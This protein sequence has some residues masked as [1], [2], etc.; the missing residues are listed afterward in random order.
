M[1]VDQTRY[2]A[3]DF[4]GARILQ[5]RE[6]NW[7]QDIDQGAAVGAVPGGSVSGQLQAVYRQGAMKNVTVSVT[8]LVVT[9]SATDGSTPM[10]IFVRDRWENYPATNDDITDNVGT[11]PANHTITLSSTDTAI[12]L[13]WELKLRTGGLIGDDPTLTDAVTNEA[14]AEAGELILHLSR[15]D[16]SGAA[17]SGSQ[18]AKNVVPVS[19]LTF[20]N[21]GSL[22]TLVPADNVLTSAK[23][24][25]TTSGFVKT[26]TSNPIVPSTD[27]SRMTDAR[28]ALDGTVHDTSVR[29]PIA[30]GGT[31]SDGTPTYNLTGDIGGVSAAKVIYVAGTQLLSDFATWIK[32]QFNNLLSRYNLHETA[33]LGLV[34]THPL[35][36][37]A[38]VGAAPA[39][40]V[41]QALGLPTSHPPVANQ[42][43]GGFRINRSGPGGSVDDP[44]YG[45][46]VSGSSIAGINHDGDVFSTKS[47]AFSAAPG[48]SLASGT[49]DHLSLIAQVLA[50]H[51]NQISHANPHGLDAGDIGAASTGYVDTAVANAISTSEA[52]TNTVTGV[53][54]RAT[55]NRT[56][57]NHGAD[58]TGLMPYGVNV[59]FM[60]Y[61]IFKFGLHFEL[62]V[63]YGAHFDQETVLLPEASGWSTTN[64]AVTANPRWVRHHYD[65]DRVGIVS[66]W[67]NAAT[68]VVTVREISQGHTPNNLD[69]WANI[70]AVFFRFV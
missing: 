22:L 34:N 16:T 44:A 24:S 27:D 70:F 65:D 49:L 10:Q 13:N 42:D 45:V 33:Q 38:Q 52:Y 59:S 9:L 46:F 6:L 1:A 62:A 25:S 56:G 69:C 63:G 43:S 4:I 7:L 57:V 23:A 58:P 47:G 12:F 3:L 14:V 61:F 64:A 39:S 60:K 40:H 18:L 50:Q 5:A 37:A 15:T 51:V 32:T 8:G 26:T 54:L 2:R 20:T 36:T 31:N 19:L 53:T 29:T 55:T 30:A 48:G 21:S 68:N 66:A 17:L 11:F 67:W 41:G 28:A 35:P